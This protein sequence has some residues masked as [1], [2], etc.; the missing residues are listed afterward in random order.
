MA[1][2][3]SRAFHI[4]SSVYGWDDETILEKTFKRIRQILALIMEEKAAQVKE[5]R[6]L[7]SWQTRSL[8][9]VMAASGG[10]ANE[11]T[12]KFAANL[13]I[14]NEEYAEFNNEQIN[15]KPSSVPVH[16]TTQE[17]EVQK[18]YESAADKNNMDMMAMFG[19]KLAEGKPG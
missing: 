8:A 14:D 15:V 6:L 18:N 17:V 5:Q 12:M 13:T 9:M 19:M 2:P 1:G 3:I 4:I 11:D 10:N 16:A 7:I